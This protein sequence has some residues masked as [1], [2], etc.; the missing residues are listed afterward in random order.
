MDSLPEFS[1]FNRRITRVM[2]D[3]SDVAHTGIPVHRLLA[4][5]ELVEQQG[6]AGSNQIDRLKGLLKDAPQKLAFRMNTVD[7][8]PPLACVAVGNDEL[9]GANATTDEKR[10]V[11]F[12]R[13]GYTPGD[14]LERSL[15]VDDNHIPRRD[16]E[17]RAIRRLRGS[18][19]AYAV[20]TLFNSSLLF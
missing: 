17:H 1:Q 18:E 11:K 6:L 8:I 12:G 20:Q 15:T 2:R 16:Y 19:L 9:V 5:S 3:Y 7:A 10:R 14:N 13:V 4:A